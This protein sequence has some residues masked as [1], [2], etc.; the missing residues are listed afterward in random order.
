MGE[1]V[2]RAPTCACIVT[3]VTI[4]PVQSGPPVAFLLYSPEV[5]FEGPCSMLG[6]GGKQARAKERKSDPRRRCR[7][8]MLRE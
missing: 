5:R 3:D 6:D 7:L 1:I 8:E 2:Q 4:G